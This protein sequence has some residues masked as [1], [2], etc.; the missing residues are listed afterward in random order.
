MT[1][2]EKFNALLKEVSIKLDEIDRETP[3]T[4]IIPK[5]WESMSNLKQ[6]IINYSIHGTRISLHMEDGRVF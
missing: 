4:E 3:Y 5:W 2:E 6:Q 1:P